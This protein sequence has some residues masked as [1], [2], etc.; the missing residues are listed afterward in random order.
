MFKKYIIPIVAVVIVALIAFFYF[1]NGDGG[2]YEF[3][4]AERSNLKQEISVT[5]KVEPAN[6]VDL[7]FESTGKVSGVY[8]NIGDRVYQGQRL[9][10]LNSAQ[11]QAQYAQANAQLEVEQV[12]LEE[13]KKGTRPEE[14]DVQKIKVK[15]AE[16]SLVDAK[17]NLVDKIRDAYTKSDDAVR[18]KVDQLFSNPRSANPQL[19]FVTDSGL[20][21][22]IESKRLVVEGI[23]KSWSVSVSN[24]LDILNDL[25]KYSNEAKNN[26]SEIGFFLDQVALATNGLNVTSTLS[27][28]TIDG[29]KTDITTARTNLNTAVSNLSAAEE[30]FR[31]AESALALANQELT[32]KEAGSTEEQIKSQES[33]IRSAE[34]NINNFGALIGKTI[35][36]SPINGIVTKINIERGE[37]VQSNTSAISVISGAEFEIETYIPEADIAKAI[38]GNSAEVTLDAYEDEVFT[39]KVTSIEPAETILDGVST[40]KTIL[41]FDTKDSRIRSGMTANID[42]MTDMKENVISVPARAVEIRDDGTKYV[43]IL[44]NGEIIQKTIETGLRSTDGLVEIISGIEEGQKV[45]TFKED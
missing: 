5:G 33:K 4:T 34:A 10:D 40:Y 44:L 43:E 16:Q 14:I 23:L 39:A 13:L 35:I 15:N 28:T 8:V 9:A 41:Q 24:S 36:Y 18:S 37:I 11:Y 3:A 32:L 1:K 7:A 17:N 20:E 21:N 42:I 45:I 2:K 22:L 19:D 29:Y 25:F 27:Q 31:T 6:K 30:K 38:V 12:R 26:L